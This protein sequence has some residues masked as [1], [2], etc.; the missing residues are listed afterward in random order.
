MLRFAV[1][2]VAAMLLSPAAAT[3]AGWALLR[4]GGHVV[5]L[6]HAMTPGGGSGEPSNFD[7]NDC[8]TQRNLSERGREQAD[9]LGVLMSVRAAP[10]ERVL[11]SRY[12]RC[13]E[14]A[15]YAFDDLKAEVFE[16]LDPL[17]ADPAAAKKQED[18]IV[19]EV[20]AFTGS[21]NLVMITH[22]EN[23]EALT[24]VSPREGEAVIVSADGDKLHVLGRIIFD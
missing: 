6:R 20:K 19:A 12:C 23:I 16:A 4:D 24:G 5:L 11:S 7:V 10:I 18:A 13:L 1:F 9:R 17:P 3:E 21:G 8:K 15:Q 14:T 2:L 22:K